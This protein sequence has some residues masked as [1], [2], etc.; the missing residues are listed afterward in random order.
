MAEQSTEFA[1]LA[2]LITGGASGIGLASARLLA[3]RGARVAVLDRVKPGAG[4]EG[5]P[6]VGRLLDAAPDP[7]A[8]RSALSARQPMG[9]LVTAD[10][11]AAAIAYLASPLAGATT[12]T[13]LAVDGGMSG[14]RV[15]P[16]PPDQDT[17]LSRAQLVG[18]TLY[19]RICAPA[20]RNLSPPGRR[21]RR[22]ESAAGPVSGPAADSRPARA[23]RVAMIR[24]APRPRPSSICPS[25]RSWPTSGPPGTA[26]RILD[27]YLPYRGPRPRPGHGRYAR[28]QPAWTPRSIVTAAV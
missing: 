3:A 24:F 19:S 15:R 12:G 10:E 7:R 22:P 9:R 17:R 28:P 11:V 2:A 13:A 6:W 8:E 5:T 1:G 14:L 16:R 21:A 20:R 25:I 18:D 26:G 4:D 27:G 23:G